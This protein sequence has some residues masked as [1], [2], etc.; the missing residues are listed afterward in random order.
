VFGSLSIL[1]NLAA[2]V[3][4]RGIGL[5]KINREIAETLEY[6]PALAKRRNFPAEQLSGGQRQLLA[7]ARGLVLRPM[8]LMLDEPT[9]GLAPLVIAEMAD[10]VAKV[11]TSFDMSVL[12]CEQNPVGPMLAADTF[13]I[14]VAGRLKQVVARSELGSNEE[15]IA[16]YMGDQGSAA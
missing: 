13:A 8:L 12:W 10:V 16:L 11:R 15:L 14:L 7:I 6:F 5:R 1:D 9:S 2:A 4:R 3:Y